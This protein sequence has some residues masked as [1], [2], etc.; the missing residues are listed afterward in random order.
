MR[1]VAKASQL[2]LVLAL[3]LLVFPSSAFAQSGAAL[4]EVICKIVSLTQNDIGK[5]LATAAIIFLCFMGMFGRISWG[6]ILVTVCGIVIVFQA[7][8]I[9]TAVTGLTPSCG[10]ASGGGGGGGGGTTGGSTG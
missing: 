3:A 2:I 9:V 7:A 4:M 5:P 1:F 10:T 6:L 8:N